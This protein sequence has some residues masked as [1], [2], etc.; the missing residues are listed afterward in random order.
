M[1]RKRIMGD[2]ERIEKKICVQLRIDRDE[3]RD[4]LLKRTT[5]IAVPLQGN[6]QDPE[7]YYDRLLL[8][9]D[10]DIW[11]GD[12][13]QEA[14][15]RVCEVLAG[16]LT[17]DGCTFDE[18]G[19][20]CMTLLLPCATVPGTADRI[21][22]IIKE[23]FVLYVLTHWFD[24]RLPEKAQYIALQYDEAIDLLKAR[25]NPGA[26]VLSCVPCGIYDSGE[27]CIRTSRRID[28][29]FFYSLFAGV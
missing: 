7:E 8:T 23:I 10:E 29:T 22:R 26:P 1:N 11:V 6:G 16:Y 24:D 9:A 14:G 28:G 2:P 3:L 12:R 5:Y 21:A 17:G 4:E 27:I 25:L 20:C 15:D 13:L 19:H 18:Q